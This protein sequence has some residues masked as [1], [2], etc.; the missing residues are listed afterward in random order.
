MTE[1]PPDSI[2]GYWC[3]TCG[4]FELTKQAWHVR[5]GSIGD[6][7]EQAEMAT[8]N[9]EVPGGEWGRLVREQEGRREFERGLIPNPLLAPV[10]R[11]AVA[12]QAMIVGV[13]PPRD[14]C[15]R[16]IKDHSEETR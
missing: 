15:A 12:R 2:E 7:C 6:R 11:D 8:I 13:E 3:P 5:A 14:A 16:I 9:Y 4:R 10:P 1:L